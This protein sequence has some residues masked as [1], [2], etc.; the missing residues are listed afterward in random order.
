VNQPVE[1]VVADLHSASASLADAAQRLQDGLVSVNDETTDL[2]GHGWKGGAASAYAPVWDKWNEGAKKVV[3][4][5]QRMSELLDIAGR[6]YAK[7]D[8]SAA[9]T[10][11]S[12]MQGQG[13][14]TT[15]GSGGSGGA[16]SAA[17]SASQIGS[18]SGVGESGSGTGD[19]AGQA[20]SSMGQLPQMAMQPLT[21]AGQAIGG[22]VQTAVQLATELAEKASDEDEPAGEKDDGAGT[23]GDSPTGTAPVDSGTPSP[24]P[25]GVERGVE[26]RGE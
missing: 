17:P 2:L 20:L 21:Q 9:E 11:G 19:A 25:E 4:G 6:E 3:E 26:T 16:A 7:T 5:L 23:S 22:L 12:A 1:V 14:A 13:G 10:V 24:S 15:S 8:Q 18:A